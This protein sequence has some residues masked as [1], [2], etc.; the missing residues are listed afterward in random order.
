MKKE[1]IIN[2]KRLVSTFID[3]ISINSPSFDEG[4]IGNYLEV[5]LRKLG[6]KVMRQKYDRSFNIIAFKKG[7]QRHALPLMLSGHM[8]T[9][10]PTEGIKYAVKGDSIRST[11]ETVLGAD[12]KSA[13]A[14][15]LEAV[16]VLDEKNILHGDI[17]VVISSGEEKGL[18][19]A[20]NLDFRKIR[21]RHALV[22]DS[23]GRVGRVVVAAPSHI[24]YE[25]R[26]IGKPAHAGIEPEKGVSAI[27]VAAEIITKVPDGRISDDTTANIGIIKGGTATNVVSKEVMV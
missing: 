19:G 10:E 1:D 12:D 4:R 6:F 2:R 26:I 15:I 20:K 13:L 24:T 11:G 5:R 23:G 9:I 17:E 27:K 16:E 3:L 21:S 8:D 25:M 14:Q 22:L 7:M 18:F